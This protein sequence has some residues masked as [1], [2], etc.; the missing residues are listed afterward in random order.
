VVSESKEA[1]SS[2]ILS[3]VSSAELVSR[4]RIA[5]ILADLL[6]VCVRD[7]RGTTAI[8]QCCAK[9]CQNPYVCRNNTV[10]EALF[11]IVFSTTFSENTK[12]Y[13][14]SLTSLVTSL[15]THPT[16]MAFLIS[17]NLDEQALMLAS[18]CKNNP[19]LFSLSLALLLPLA[20]YLTL[21]ALA[22]ILSLSKPL[23]FHP[24]VCVCVLKILLGRVLVR[25]VADTIVSN[26]DLRDLLENVLNN[27]HL[28]E[29]WDDSELGSRVAVSSWSSETSGKREKPSIVEKEEVMKF[30][31]V[32]DFSQKRKSIDSRQSRILAAEMVVRL[33][34]L[35]AKIEPLKHVLHVMLFNSI[36]IDYLLSYGF[37]AAKALISLSDDADQHNVRRDMEHIT[38]LVEKIPRGDIT[39]YERIAKDNLLMD[40]YGDAQTH[41]Y[42]TKALSI[43]HSLGLRLLQFVQTLY[44]HKPDHLHVVLHSRYDGSY[45]SLIHHVLSLS[46][47]VD[48]ENEFIIAADL[49]CVIA[50]ELS[51]E[52]IREVHFMAY[53]A[54]ENGW[55]DSIEHIIKLCE[56]LQDLSSPDELTDLFIKCIVTIST[57]L[58]E[59][60]WR[61]EKIRRQESFMLQSIITQKLE[62][63]IL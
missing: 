11:N 24:S 62:D 49:M 29:Q 28:S 27:F 18:K 41:V 34:D 61:D 63:I 14:S 38:K 57:T 39:E 58:V 37:V 8:V 48:D 47:H 53:T 20:P 31:V 42:L 3:L 5:A 50:D 10:S 35:T 32:D 33:C 30:D 44:L 36:H 1:S 25:N 23:F 17:R 9:L 43:G 60:R 40:A 2:R 26:K 13:I 54:L 15:S 52:L 16:H 51:G 45:V 46:K 19:K 4:R 56:K 6:S 55:N 21:G 22:S 12:H 7:V 59:Y